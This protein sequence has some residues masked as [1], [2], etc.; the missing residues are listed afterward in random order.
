MK[1]RVWL[2]GL[3]LIIPG[4]AA[5][6]E[7]EP[8]PDI[9]PVEN[10]YIELKKDKDNFELDK[11]KKYFIKFPSPSRDHFYLVLVTRSKPAI[12]SYLTEKFNDGKGEIVPIV[13]EAVSNDST[14]VYAIGP[15]VVTYYW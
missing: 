9:L 11:D 15:Q 1:A 7:L 6:K 2:A 4:C 10:G 12:H 3:L 5:Y 8:K 13:D 14:F